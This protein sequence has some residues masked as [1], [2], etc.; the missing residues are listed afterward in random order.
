M[1]EAACAVSVPG[2][3][4]VSVKVSVGNGGLGILIQARY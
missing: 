1:A 4:K 2:S 3:V